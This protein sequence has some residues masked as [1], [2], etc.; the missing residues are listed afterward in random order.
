MA[1]YPYSIFVPDTNAFHPNLKGGCMVENWQKPWNYW[2]GKVGSV[3]MQIC[4]LRSPKGILFSCGDKNLTSSWPTLEEAA[5]NVNR[6]V[7]S[8]QA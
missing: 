1:N 7:A 4:G 6:F 2:I 3:H 5:M 8:A